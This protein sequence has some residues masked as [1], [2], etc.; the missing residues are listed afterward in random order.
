MSYVNIG[1]M[2]PNI[3]V[4]PSNTA[5]ELEQSTYT[6]YY[7]QPVAEENAQVSNIEMIISLATLTRKTYYDR[8]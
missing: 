6:N 2:E 8:H 5:N 4:H 1:P 7:I 3:T